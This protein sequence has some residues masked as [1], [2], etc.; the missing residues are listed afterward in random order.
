VPI[1]CVRGW[2][3]SF[4]HSGSISEG[5]IFGF[6]IYV[7]N[8]LLF[9]TILLEQNILRSLVNLCAFCTVSNT[10]LVSLVALGT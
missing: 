3:V 4:L 2:S 5:Y 1:S 9:Q 6:D 7:E 10:L 8:E